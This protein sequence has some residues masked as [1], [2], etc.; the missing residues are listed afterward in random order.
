MTL[1]RGGRH[2]IALPAHL[3]GQAVGHRDALHFLLDGPGPD[4]L[5]FLL[6]GHGPHHEP[7]G[8]QASADA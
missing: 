5:S 8:R 7:A 1:Q 2:R 6:N 3:A 4:P